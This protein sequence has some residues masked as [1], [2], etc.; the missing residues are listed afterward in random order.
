MKLDSVDGVIS[1][2]ANRVE[3]ITDEGRA[4]INW[5]ASNIVQLY[6]QD[7]GRTLKIFI[8]QNREVPTHVDFYRYVETN[9][10]KVEMDNR[11]RCFINK[12]EGIRTLTIEEVYQEFTKTNL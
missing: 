7:E 3:V 9:Y 11:G 5:K 1:T 4:Y 2:N 8:S 12:N 10:N 6:L